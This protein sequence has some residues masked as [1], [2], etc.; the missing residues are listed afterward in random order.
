M[1]MNKIP[2]AARHKGKNISVNYEKRAQKQA[3]RLSE[4]LAHFTAGEGQPGFAATDL[5]KLARNLRRSQ[6]LKPEQRAEIEQLLQQGDAAL[7]SHEVIVQVKAALDGEGGAGR[8]VTG[9][10]ALAILSQAQGMPEAALKDLKA[11]VLSTISARDHWDSTADARTVFAQFLGVSVDRLPAPKTTQ[12]QSTAAFTKARNEAGPKNI[13]RAEFKEIEAGLK[14]LPAPLRE[15]TLASILGGSKEGLIK[16]DPQSRKKM[17][18]AVATGFAE[19]SEQALEMRDNSSLMASGNYLTQIIASGGSFEDILFAFLLM[20]ADKA[21][22]DAETAMQELADMDA[23][24][25]PE[26]SQAAQGDSVETGASSAGTEKPAST[27]G[28]AG[29]GA[30]SQGDVKKTA[31]IME[32]MVQSADHAGSA[33]SDGG[34]KVTQKEAK[35]LVGYLQ[36]LPGGVQKLLAGSLEKAIQAGGVPLTGNAHLAIS[37]WGQNIMGRPFHIDADGSGREATPANTEMAKALRNSD[38]LEDRFA[39]FIVDTLYKPDI[40]LKEKMK[41]FK[42]LR[43]AMGEAADISKQTASTQPVGA[44]GSTQKTGAAD[45]AADASKQGIGV[46]PKA[47][48]KHSASEDFVLKPPTSVFGDENVPEVNYGPGEGEGGGSKISAQHK[49]Q[50]AMNN[51][52]RVLDMLSNIMK[53]I[54]DTQMTAVRNLR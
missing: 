6:N 49:L 30:L 8:P 11:Q 39:S 40:S 36:R 7:K 46:E 45:L 41:P 37:E 48:K 2:S 1:A 43:K 14:D 42:S 12:T 34:T 20:M 47:A 3:S 23:G 27:D 24:K 33:K 52:Q 44:N 18:R 29:F 4:S 26:A 32:S 35:R 17:T 5:Q 19:G 21:D 50:M 38:K 31:K 15:T 53:A 51:R 9:E 16:L 54:H 22:K 25:K 10:A 13:S 28:Q